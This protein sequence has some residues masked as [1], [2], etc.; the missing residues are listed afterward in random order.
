MND[1]WLH[2]FVLHRRPYRETSVIVDFFTLETG[3]VSAVV[4]GARKSH[5]AKKSLLEPLQP[6]TIL[7]AG[8][9]ELKTLRQIE[10]DGVLTRLTG[11]RLFCA[12]YV[13]ELL[14][15][16]LPPY[17]AVDDMYRHYCHTLSELVH[18]PIEPTLRQFEF[19]L[20][21]ELGL[22]PDMLQDANTLEP[23]EPHICYQYFP[24]SGVQVCMPSARNA[25]AGSAILSIVDQQWNDEAVR[26][27]KYIARVTLAGVLGSKP[28]KSRELFKPV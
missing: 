24:D 12:M 18:S 2:G 8:K 15:R 10:S 27:A 23:V 5:S 20:L 9:A 6:V 19:A 21:Q 25:I 1:D 17:M 11:Q 28:L 4:K 22:L 14:N 26:A 13:N 7:L 16:V 3:R